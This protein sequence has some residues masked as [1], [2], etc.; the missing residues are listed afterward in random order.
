MQCLVRDWFPC[1]PS[2]F[3]VLVLQYFFN[4]VNDKSVGNQDAEEES[5]L[6]VC[7]FSSILFSVQSLK[8]KLKSALICFP[9]NLFKSKNLNFIY[10]YKLFCGVT[11][12]T[13]CV[14]LCEEW[15]CLFIQVL[16][17]MCRNNDGVFWFTKTLVNL[18]E[19]HDYLVF[20]VRCC[21]SWHWKFITATHTHYC[22]KVS[23]I[24]D[25]AN[26]NDTLI[27]KNKRNAPDGILPGVFYYGA[28]LLLTEHRTKATSH[29]QFCFV[30]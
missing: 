19:R 14:F 13:I 22:A 11:S 28:E 21:G 4:V 2:I 16:G 17:W 7:L 18:C 12:T 25:D 23:W 26:F 3:C 5:C 10:C 30:F 24:Y 27:N 9:L 1:V 8:L 15:S 20:T 6:F 29:L